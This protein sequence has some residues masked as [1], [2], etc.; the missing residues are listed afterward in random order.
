MLMQCTHEE[1]KIIIIRFISKNQVKNELLSIV[2]VPS[3][4]T[5]IKQNC[6]VFS[7][8][9]HK[10]KH[11]KIKLLVMNKNN[12]KREQTLKTKCI[13]NSQLYWSL[14]C[15]NYCSLL[16]DIDTIKELPH[17]LVLD[18]TFLQNKAKKNKPLND[19]SV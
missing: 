1:P 16:A 15:S 12:S 7:K 10:K 13:Y 11:H 14:I 17:I 3:L 6:S 18:M 5:V 8:G 19:L 9:R 4:K 2:F